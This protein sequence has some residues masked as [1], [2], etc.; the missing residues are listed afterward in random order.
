[1]IR[2]YYLAALSQCRKLVRLDL[3][4][5]RGTPLILDLLRAVSTLSCLK[6]FCFPCGSLFSSVWGEND[7]GRYQAS[8]KWP[9]SLETFHIP[10]SL[11][12]AYL[13]AFENAPA[14]LKSLVVA[15]SDQIFDVA[16][17]TVFGLIGSRIVTLKVD[18][19]EDDFTGQLFNI[20]AKFP[21]LLYLSVCATLLWDPTM[22]ATDLEIDH[23]LRSF[24]ILLDDLDD[25]S[26]PYFIEGIEILFNKGWLPDIRTLLLSNRESMTHLAHHLRINS[27]PVT[28]TKILRLLEIGKRLKQRSS[29]ASDQRE[30][31]VWIVDGKNNDAVIGELT[32]ENIA[33]NMGLAPRVCYKLV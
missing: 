13:Q 22:R 4:L 9:D 6:I 27:S 7:H 21:N 31:G 8:L 33:R 3:S 15:G 18:Y 10:N 23:P 20:F 12:R 30:S 16:P 2:V 29:S 26:D 28:N 19:E 5:I 11:S 14:S 25:I 17:N 32:E 24:T 1:L